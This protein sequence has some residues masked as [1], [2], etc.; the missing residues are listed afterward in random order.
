[1][2]AISVSSFVRII[3]FP[4]VK[5]LGPCGYPLVN[6]MKMARTVQLWG[7]ELP[8]SWMFG[9]DPAFLVADLE[10]QGWFVY[11]LNPVASQPAGWDM[12]CL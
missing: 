7:Y 3:L 10:I 4:T 12:S 5:S 2:G 6:I 9:I 8:I 1:M 11:D